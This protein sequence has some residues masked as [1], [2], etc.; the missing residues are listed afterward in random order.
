[1][2]NDAVLA[3]AKQKRKSEAV[4]ISAFKDSIEIPSIHFPPQ[5]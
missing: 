5:R 4:E 2:E 1:M 3:E